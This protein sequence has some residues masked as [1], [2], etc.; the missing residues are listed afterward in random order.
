MKR[1]IRNNP[2]LLQNPDLDD[3]SNT[4]LHLAASN[5]LVEIADFLSQAGHEANEISRNVDH[6]TPLMLAAQ[7][8]HVEIGELL[9][10]SF[11][12]SA[13]Y[14]NKTGLDALAMACQ[15]SESTALIPIL[16]DN[17][18]NPASVDV[19]DQDGNTP[20][21]HASASGSLKAL[22]VLL[23]AGANP[24]AKNNSDWTP[25]AYTQ[26]VAAEVYFKNLVV[27]FERRKVEGLRLAEERERQRA[28][29]MR[30][31][32]DGSATMPRSPMD[33]EEMME[34]LKRHLKSTQSLRPV[35]SGSFGRYDWEGRP[36][37]SRT[38]SGSES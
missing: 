6:D 10:K 28:A 21:H 37:G 16:L 24:L 9:V 34:G 8:G 3:K 31:V 19:R 15:H 27:E 11:P 36:V 12:F 20:L 13:T 17:A 38:R 22:R 29:G 35:P 4:N 25:L 1:L 18:A 2:H 7:K 14:T 33:D 23:A 26:T 30:V 5:G 32:D